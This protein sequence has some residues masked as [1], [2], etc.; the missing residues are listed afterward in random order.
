MADGMSIKEAAG[1]VGLEPQVL[2]QLHREGIIANPL[3][4]EELKGLT[5]L[6]ATWGKEWYVR[7]QAQALRPAKRRVVLM[8]PELD[9]VDRYILRCYL[10]LPK[11]KRLQTEDVRAKVEKY[12]GVKVAEEK[13]FRVREIAYDLRQGR[14]K[15][16]AEALAKSG[17][18]HTPN[19][20]K[21]PK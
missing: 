6:A 1:L 19:L 12:L 9:R 20:E 8:A 4:A 2:W 13:I 5:I 10:N 15:N 17:K 18:P 16:L 7:R 14:R 3:S 11:G 21:S